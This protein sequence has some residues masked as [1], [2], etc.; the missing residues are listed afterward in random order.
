[1]K[2]MFQGDITPDCDLPV[3]LSSKKYSIQ[4]HLYRI[5]GG[6]FSSEK[7]VALCFFN[8]EVHNNLKDS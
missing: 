7:N 4:R 2:K 3:K 8:I 6:T 1:M 5:G